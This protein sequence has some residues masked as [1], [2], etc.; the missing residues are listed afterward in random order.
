[1]DL[2]RSIRTVLI[3][4]THPGNI[5][6]VARA[7]K[8]MGL[9]QLYLVEPSRY[10]S[11]EAMARAADAEDVLARAV[12]CRD[13]DEAL[14]DCHFVVGT[15]ARARHIEW[16]AL[17]PA[18]CARRLLS[19]AGRGPVAV[20]FGPERTGLAN[21]ELD[22]CHIV[23]YI[24]SNPAYPSLNLVCAVQI[25][26]Y[27][28]YRAAAGATAPTAMLSD[29]PATDEEMRH[30]HRHLE[31][32]LIEIGFLDPRNPRLLPRRL[33]RFFN[34]AQP[35]KNEVNILRGLLTAVQNIG[36]KLDNNS[37]E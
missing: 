37:R 9:E 8:N 19:E 11:A 30:F 29:P 7:L 15:T 23:A 27:E 6:G 4:P 14:A 20:L 12:V 21:A 10:P 1:M 22:R 5:G 24:P 28:M 33:R 13:L 32:V 3:R 18:G 26:A 36:R 2:L 31:E 16:P 17:E 34:R 25:L 35:D